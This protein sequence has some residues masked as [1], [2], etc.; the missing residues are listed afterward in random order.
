MNYK[1]QVI[2]VLH[3]TLKYDRLLSPVYYNRVQIYYNTVFNFIPEILWFCDFFSKYK[4][5]PVNFGFYCWILRFF[6]SRGLNTPLHEKTEG[7]TYKSNLHCNY[8]LICDTV[9]FV[10]VNGPASLQS[11]SLSTVSCLNERTDDPDLAAAP[12]ATKV[13]NNVMSSSKANRD[14]HCVCARMCSVAVRIWK[15]LWWIWMG[16]LLHGLGQC[17]RERDKDWQRE[18]RK[19]EFSLKMVWNLWIRRLCCDSTH[20]FC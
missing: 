18:E 7:Q 4:L 8:P 5:F 9:V 11:L 3:L 1:F 6:L 12:W 19:S 16:S 10:P 13:A 15:G 17:F 2:H 20:D 14:V